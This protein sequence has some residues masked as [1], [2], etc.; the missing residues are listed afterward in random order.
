MYKVGIYLR[1]SN[2]DGDKQ[3]SDSISSQR[4]IIMNYIDRQSDMVFIREFADD[5]YTGTNFKRPGFEELLRDIELGHINCVI[6]KDLSRLGRNY[7]LTG[8]YL[9]HYFP[10]KGIRFIAINDNYDSFNSSAKNS[11]SLR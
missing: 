3:E 9:E 2:D 5:G 4:N 1:L 8:Q 7:V 10:M 11:S 6:V